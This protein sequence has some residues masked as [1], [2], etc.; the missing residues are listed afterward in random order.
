MADAMREETV[1]LNAVHRMTELEETRDEAGIH[2]VIGIGIGI[3][4]KHKTRPQRMVMVIIPVAT[5]TA[6]A[7][8]IATATATATLVP[9]TQIK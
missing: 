1:V 7:T 9:G 6:T 4:T 3:R 5:A 8:A 2:A